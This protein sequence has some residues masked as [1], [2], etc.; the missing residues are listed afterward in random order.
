MPG[1]EQHTAATTLVRDILEGIHQVGDAPQA[2][3]EAETEC[4]GMRRAARLVRSI[5][6]GS[7]AAC[8]AVCWRG[9]ALEIGNRG[10]GL[11]DGAAWLLG[12]HTGLWLLLGGL[13]VG[14]LGLLGRR[15]AGELAWLLLVLC[16]GIVVDG[17][18][19]SHVWGLGVLLH[20]DVCLLHND[21]GI[22]S[23]VNLWSDRRS[24]VL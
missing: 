8:G 1:R 21:I 14:A 10:C 13:H 23:Q 5:C 16:V 11:V 4:P 20:G 15:R 19:A 24:V 9:T 18:L 6:Q 2:E 3:A 17:G 12:W 7:L 22:L